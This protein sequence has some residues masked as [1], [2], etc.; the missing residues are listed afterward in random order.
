MF[1][2]GT[3]IEFF[4]DEGFTLKGDYKYLACQDGQWD[5]AAQIS[6]VSQG[7]SKYK[8]VTEAQVYLKY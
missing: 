7:M 2:H 1:S 8:L 3:V 4:C 5:G 6:C